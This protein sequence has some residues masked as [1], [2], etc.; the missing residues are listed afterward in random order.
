[1]KNKITKLFLALLAITLGN[2]AIAQEQ[3]QPMPDYVRKATNVE[4]LNNFAKEKSEE[5]DRRYLR[6]VQIAEEKGMP[7]GGSADG[8]AFSLVNYEDETGALIY[9][10]TFNN[11]A[12]A[13][14]L[15]TANAKELHTNGVIGTGMNVGIWDGGVLTI[16]HLGFM[17]AGVNRYSVKDTGNNF[18]G[19]NQDGREHGPHV[20][21]TVAAGTF[22]NGDGKGF[23][24]GSKVLAYNWINDL[25]E[26]ATAAAS[27][28]API[29]TSNHSYG[30]N[31][32]NYIGSG[33]LVSIFGLY[34]SEA[35]SYDVLANNAPYYTIVFAA[36]NDRDA[37]YNP[38][39]NKKDLLSQA[40][41]SKNV[42]VVAATRGTEDYTGITGTASVSGS[43]PFIAPFSNYGP[44][45]DFRIKPDIAAKGM[46]VTSIGITGN[47]S[48]DVMSGT[49]MAAPAVTGV[50]TM[51]QGYHNDVFGRYMKSATVR[52]LMAHTAREAGPAAGPDFMFGWGLIDAGKGK[53]VMDAVTDTLAVMQELN[54]AQGTTYEYVFPYDG[55]E[56]LVVTMAWNDPAGTADT[57]GDVNLKKLVN[58]LDITLT[59]VTTGKVFYPWALDR[60]WSTLPTSS[61]I[62]VR[63]ARNERD[64]IEKIEFLT[65]ADKIAGDYKVTINHTGT[66]QGG[67]QDYS[68]I[69]SGASKGSVSV[70]DFVLNNLS[71]YPN[72][73]NSVL[74]IA[75]DLEILA[76]ASYKVFDVSG[77]EVK[78]QDLKFSSNQTAIDVSSLQEGV[79]VLVISK[80]GAKKSYKFIKK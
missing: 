23:A 80:D 64:N 67:S 75:G 47:N 35:R 2:N 78:S 33:G 69:I 43:N 71:I 25:S 37:N 57:T 76:N 8:N 21:G 48:T 12:N 56:D 60:K 52:A 32:A 31:T 68:L 15:K 6:A 16:N 10:S 17:T 26:M 79:Y 72:P 62:A 70:D 51:W 28:S 20:A 74:N 54:L 18:P 9:Y 30:L 14:S 49:S 45:N 61:T 65:S 4:F 36:G 5:F 7:I 38:A 44:T 55:V 53:L 3:E 24:Y 34:T 66:L 73:T 27:T 63:N 39:K 22:G 13:S 40:G 42:V 11:S 58:D 29:Y 19:N 50:L 46:N 77:K 41:V 1:M 59:N